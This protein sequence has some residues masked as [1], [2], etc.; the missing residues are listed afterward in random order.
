MANNDDEH[1]HGD[2]AVM[3]RDEQ[4]V[5]LAAVLGLEEDLVACREKLEASGWDLQRAVDVALGANSQAD[6]SAAAVAGGGDA[7][8]L[9]RRHGAPTPPTSRRR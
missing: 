2:D 8:G 6:T 1:D 5:T 3:Q 7:G 4:V 9:R